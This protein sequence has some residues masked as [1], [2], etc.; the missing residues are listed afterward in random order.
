MPGEQL[1]EV[2]GVVL[3]LALREGAPEHADQGCALEQRQVGRQGRDAAAGGEADHQEAAVPG[4]GAEGLLEQFA[5][6]RI[7]DHIHALAAGELLHLVLEA[8]LAVVDQVVGAGVA[9]HFQLLGSARR[10]DHLGAHGLADF[11]R[12]QAD[13]AG[14]TE[15][16]QGLALLQVGALLQRMHRGAVGHAEGGGGGQVHALGYRQHVVAGHRHFLGEAAPAGQGHDPV[17]GAQV[18]D[19]LADRLDHA[20]RLAARGEREGRLEL[21]LALNDQGVGEVDPGG[22]YLDQ[23]LVLLRFRAGQV[24]QDQAGGRAE[25]FAEQGFHRAFLAFVIAGSVGGPPGGS[26]SMVTPDG[27]P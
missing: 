14:S 26:T 17:A 3:R 11:H 20:G 18:R 5:T 9:R 4:D 27:T 21:V 8:L 1:L 19:L 24:F 15:H 13:T 16:Q 10:G 22:M 12:R 2:G 6:H 7:V 23:H 25:G